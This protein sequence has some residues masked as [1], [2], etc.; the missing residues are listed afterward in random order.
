MILQGIELNQDQVDHKL[1]SVCDGIGPS[2]KE[3]S[4]EHLSELYIDYE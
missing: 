3:K 1:R 4:I 2:S